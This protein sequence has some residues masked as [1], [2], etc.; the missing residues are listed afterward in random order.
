MLDVTLPKLLRELKRREHLPM[1]FA[2]SRQK[3]VDR[4]LTLVFFHNICEIRLLLKQFA[5]S[6]AFFF[7]FFFFFEDCFLWCVDHFLMSLF[8]A[9]PRK[10]V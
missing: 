1:L 6:A 2:N 3:Y 5:M 4:S 7:F 9:D 10:I 8:L